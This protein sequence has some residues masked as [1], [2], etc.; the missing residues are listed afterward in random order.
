M[1]VI[2]TC[3]PID[4]GVTTHLKTMDDTTT[5]TQYLPF[6]NWIDFCKEVEQMNDLKMIIFGGALGEEY[7]KAIY[8][9]RR[10]LP[11]VK[12]GLLFCSPF[13]QADLC[14]EFPLLEEAL[15]FN[16][17]YLFTGDYDLAQL[18]NGTWL[19]QTM[20]LKPFD[21]Y[22]LHSNNKNNEVG[23][24]VSTVPQKNVANQII[25]CKDVEGLNL[26]VNGVADKYK[27]LLG[28]NFMDVGFVKSKQEFYEIISKCKIGLQVNF[29]ESFNYMAAEFMAM[30]VPCL[31][32]SCMPHF[33]ENDSFLK[34]FLLVENFDSPLEIREK[35][36]SIMN[37][38]DKTYESL[39]RLCIKRVHKEMNTRVEI[40]ND[41]LTKLLN[42]T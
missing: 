6:H 27:F 30:G 10:K 39:S 11:K 25:A 31:V 21:K 4:N 2:T 18:L 17:D 32:S 19:P 13:G 42:N 20:D 33:Y 41:T 7:Q 34:S 8:R 35:I 24:F 5:L 16:L 15:K 37:M 23:L 28:K 36:Q 9:L 29:S 14:N 26:L 1:Q 40:V 12:I 38:N 22:R 3:P